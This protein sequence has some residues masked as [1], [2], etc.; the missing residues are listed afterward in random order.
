VLS[1]FLLVNSASAATV[2]KA[3]NE[4]KPLIVKSIQSSKNVIIA[5]AT[6]VDQSGEVASKVNINDADIQMLSENL[7]GIGLK[8]AQAIVDWREQ[9]GNFISLEQ[10]LEVKGIGEKTL[11]ANRALMRI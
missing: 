1:I 2:D 7:K 11:L 5:A 4:I 9:N 10:L 8:K 3:I 6:Q